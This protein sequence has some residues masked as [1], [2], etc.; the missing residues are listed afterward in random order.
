MNI[1]VEDKSKMS[2]WI[3][4][5]IAGAFKK[6][7]VF[8]PATFKPTPLQMKK[9]LEE[10][11]GQGLDLI[12]L[13]NDWKAYG[14]TQKELLVCDSDPEIQGLCVP[15]DEGDTERTGDKIIEDCLGLLKQKR[16]L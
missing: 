2:R 9:F 1:W 10:C 5:A 6:A 14:R 3:A 12:V 11:S 13:S 15:M 7:L 8:V 16:L 4:T